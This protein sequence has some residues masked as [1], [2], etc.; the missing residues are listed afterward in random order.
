MDSDWV[1]ASL[2]AGLLAAVAYHVDGHVGLHPDLR[3]AAGTVVRRYGVKSSRQLD[4]QLRRFRDAHFHHLSPALRHDLLRTLQRHAESHDDFAAAARATP[5][6]GAAPGLAG[7]RGCRRQVAAPTPTA[8]TRTRAPPRARPSPGSSATTTGPGR[9]PAGAPCAAGART[10]GPRRPSGRRRPGGLTGW[11]SAGPRT[12]PTCSAGAARPPAV[13]T[14]SAVARRGRRRRHRR[15]RGAGPVRLLRQ[16]Q[17]RWRAARGA[18][19]LVV[20]AECVEALQRAPWALHPDRRAAGRDAGLGPRAAASCAAWTLRGAPDRAPRVGARGAVMLLVAGWLVA[21][22]PGWAPFCCWRRPWARR[23]RSWAPR[24][25]RGAGRWPGPCPGA[26]MARGS[27]SCASGRRR[28]PRQGMTPARTAR[29]AGAGGASFPVGPRV[30]VRV[31]GLEEDPRQVR[32]APAPT[33]ASGAARVRPGPVHGDDPRRRSARRCCT[34]AGALSARACVP[35]RAAPP[36]TTRT[37]ARGRAI[38]DVG[39]SRVRALSP[40]HAGHEEVHAGRG[41]VRRVDRP[42]G[43]GAHRHP[44]RGGGAARAPGAAGPVRA[45]GRGPVAASSLAVAGLQNCRRRRAHRRRRWR[46]QLDA[47]LPGQLQPDRHG[48]SRGR[49]SGRCRRRRWLAPRR[50]GPAPP[51]SAPA[52]QVPVPGQAHAAVLAAAPGPAPSGPDLGLGHRGAH[53]AAVPLPAPS[54]A[55]ALAQA[56]AEGLPVHGGAGAFVRGRRVTSRMSTD[57]V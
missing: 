10:G 48:C 20:A 9:P 56:G 11:P 40:G 28:P 32:A 15:P 42:P 44:E 31:C 37:A 52:P 14:W 41:P 23:R 7:C 6:S 13:I 55:P 46:P 16:V 5:A 3:R 49:A 27:G 45:R 29:V 17:D 51:R 1:A 24:R 43:V 12:C 36:S 50:C 57:A 39:Q 35:R 54:L 4:A 38:L 26:G 18:A 8:T 30:G 33:R 25:G 22:A 53:G 47:Q 19:A 2:D 34:V 21:G